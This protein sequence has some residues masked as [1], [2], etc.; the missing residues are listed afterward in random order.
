VLNAIN[1]SQYIHSAFFELGNGIEEVLLTVD[2]HFVTHTNSGANDGE[3]TKSMK[4]YSV[5]AHR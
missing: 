4:P 2:R 5:H 1:S 3:I